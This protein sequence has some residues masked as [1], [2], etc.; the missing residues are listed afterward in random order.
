[1]PSAARKDILPNGGGGVWVHGIQRC[2]RRAYLCGTDASGRNVDY[3]K[4]WIERRLRELS[5]A[6]PVEVSAYAVMSNHVHVVLRMRPDW[7]E[8][9]DDQAV[10][11]SW[12]RIFPG[13]Q[14]A[15]N[16]DG[17]LQDPAPETVALYAQNTAWVQERRKR[18][19]SISWFMRTFAEPIARRAN[20][21]DGCTGHFWEGRFTSVPLLDYKAL[22]ACMA[23]VD[24]N[25]IRAKI[26]DS[27][28]NSTHTGARTRIEAR[29]GFVAA[30]RL[31]KSGNSKKASETAVQ[32]GLTSKPEHQ[33]DGLWLAPL[34]SCM[35]R[36]PAK[37]V[38]RPLAGGSRYIQKGG[39]LPALSADDYLQLLDATG[40]LF[41]TGKRGA[42]PQ[43]LAPI[44]TR[45]EIDLN[46]WLATMQGWREFLGRVVGDFTARATEASQR[47]KRW[48]QNRCSLFANS[49]PAEQ[50]TA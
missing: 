37:G 47:G 31:K 4:D 23:Y 17:T 21:E 29:Q 35:V 13:P 14:A 25:P 32:C 19:A 20:K 33:E 48:L 28:E 8:T 7:L 18:L 49:K 40:R 2:V 43:E 38:D 36:N 5:A 50:K 27:P 41:Q 42:I 9:W 10:V 22:I 30:Q 3:R 26:A 44:L 1:M 6:F 45:L 12:L 16:A 24:L 34:L 46:A 39:F 11:R 15:R